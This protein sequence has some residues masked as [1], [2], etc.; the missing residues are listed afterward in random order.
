[1]VTVIGNGDYN[2]ITLPSN[3]NINL[4]KPSYEFVSPYCYKKPNVTELLS[5]PKNKQYM[6]LFQHLVFRGQVLEPSDILIHHHCNLSVE[7]INII[8][9]TLLKLMSSMNEEKENS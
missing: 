3:M 5:A 1:M 9:V 2:K 7:E 4:H 6:T 8:L